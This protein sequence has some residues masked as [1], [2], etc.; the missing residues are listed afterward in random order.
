MLGPRYA[1]VN[2]G[3]EKKVPGSGRVHES[4]E[5]GGLKVE[6]DLRAERVAR[7]VTRISWKADAMLPGKGN[8]NSH[9]ARPVHQI[10]SMIMWI[11]TSSLSMKNLLALSTSLI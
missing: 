6:A 2:F 10:V 11:W 1:S 8:L 4:A 3:E 9:G 5:V 7:Y